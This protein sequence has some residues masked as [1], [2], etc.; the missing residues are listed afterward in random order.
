MVAHSN[1]PRRRN[2]IDKDPPIPKKNTTRKKRS[3][4]VSSMSSVDN[5]EFI[6]T[7]GKP[8]TC[9]ASEVSIQ[10]SPCTPCDVPADVPPIIQ[11]LT[12]VPNPVDDSIVI[13]KKACRKKQEPKAKEAK[14]KDKKE[15]KMSPRKISEKSKKTSHKK[16]SGSEKKKKIGPEKKKSKPEKKKAEKKSATVKKS[17]KKGETV[18]AEKMPSDKRTS[19]KGLAEAVIVAEEAVSAEK[20]LS[21]TITSQ[22]GSSKSVLLLEKK[23]AEQSLPDKKATPSALSDKKA[24]PSALSDKKATSSALSDKKATSSALSDKKATSSALSDKKATSSA[25]SD[26]KAT[27]SALLS[28]KKASAPQ[29]I[30]E[31]VAL[32]DKKA[33][34]SA[35]PDKKATSSALPD[36]K[37]TSSALSDK[38]ATSSALSDKKA[39]S[40]VLSDKK[41][42]SS[43]KTASQEKSEHTASPEKQQVASEMPHVPS[44]IAME[45]KDVSGKKKRSSKSKKKDN[46]TADGKKASRKKSSTDKTG[47]K[48]IRGDAKERPSRTRKN[49][50]VKKEHSSPPSEVSRRSIE[51]TPSESTPPATPAVTPSE[52]IVTPEP[53]KVVAVS[54]C[55]LVKTETSATTQINADHVTEVRSDVSRLSKRAGSDTGSGVSKVKRRKATSDAVDAKVVIPARS[56]RRPSS[57]IEGPAKKQKVD[58]KPITIRL[59]TKPR[60]PPVPQVTAALSPGSSTHSTPT[61]SVLAP[62]RL[63]PPKKK[64]K[65]RPPSRLEALKKK[66]TPVS[67]YIDP[68][69]PR[70]PALPK[71]KKRYRDPTKAMTPTSSVISAAVPPP[72]PVRVHVQTSL[73]TPTKKPLSP[74]FEAFSYAK[75]IG[76]DLKKTMIHAPGKR[77]ATLTELHS[78]AE[79]IEDEESENDPAEKQ[80]AAVEAFGERTWNHEASVADFIPAEPRLLTLHV[81]WAV[82]LDTPQETDISTIVMSEPCQVPHWYISV[83]KE[84]KLPLPPLPEGPVVRIQDIPELAVSDVYL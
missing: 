33:T 27:S 76:L 66:L 37:A 3:D 7:F 74:C 50:D 45:T 16:K 10:V 51:L 80:S 46:R 30:S 39:T 65:A 13:P 75:K 52:Q 25:L 71:L 4:S 11:P 28:E 9:V 73:I 24:T 17:G 8:K 62:P 57:L 55:D 48:E 54:C 84:T 35:L 64:P 70:V 60:D 5:E 68:D 69:E 44:Q 82:V 42:T 41:A 34:S 31:T 79:E 21:E 22:T 56:K 63:E 59:K 61:P 19:Q 47:K 43:Q 77:V 29:K 32:P 23:T 49:T 6:S 58:A 26:K 53:N 36:K 2:K 20:V 78:E 72:A 14:S 1:E 18:S 15:P 12:P 83:A 40:S 81:D 38:K 67:E